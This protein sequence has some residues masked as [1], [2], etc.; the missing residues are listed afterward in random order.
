M[1]PLSSQPTNSVLRAFSSIVASSARSAR[2]I[3]LASSISDGAIT[4]GTS[5]PQFCSQPCGSGLPRSWNSQPTVLLPSA[6][7]SE[8]GQVMSSVSIA[9]EMNTRPPMPL[10]C[11]GSASTKVS[12][13][14]RHQSELR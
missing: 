10:A 6:S 7:Q 12:S 5:P 1:S 4:A 14:R 3:W 9:L 2:A 13:S 11:P 8:A